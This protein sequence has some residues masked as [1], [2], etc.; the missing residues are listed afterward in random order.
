MT[1]K[2]KLLS[3]STAAAASVAP[4][5]A[6]AHEGEGSFYGHHMWG[7]GGYG[8]FFGP[9]MMIMFIAVA[10]VVVVLLVRWLGTSGHGGVAPHP[11]GKTPLKI[12]R[13][14]SQEVR[15]TRRS[16][17]SGDACWM[18]RTSG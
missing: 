3:A 4:I 13:N 6:N 1:L 17:R 2:K 7:G 5:V 15:S 12:S 18:N 10:V 9:I 14:G 8:W 16:S 11:P